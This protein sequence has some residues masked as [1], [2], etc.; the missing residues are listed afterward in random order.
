MHEYVI[1]FS[2]VLYPLTAYLSYCKSSQWK[3]NAFKTETTHII[4]LSDERH[5]FKN[6][7]RY[8]FKWLIYDFTV[9]IHIHV[10]SLIK[11]C[12]S[13]VVYPKGWDTCIWKG[14]TEF[15]SSMFVNYMF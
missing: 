6:F 13:F 8:F 9:Y 15:I 14:N 12:K 10:H 2:S 4:W 11:S 5:F 1:I 3:I 7:A